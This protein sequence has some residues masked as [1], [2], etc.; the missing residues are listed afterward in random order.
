VNGKLTGDCIWFDSKTDKGMMEAHLIES[1]EVM[2]FAEQESQIRRL[3]FIEVGQINL[4][5]AIFAFSAMLMKYGPIKIYLGIHYVYCLGAYLSN[6][7][8]HKETNKMAFDTETKTKK[9]RKV[10][11]MVGRQKL[12]VPFVYDQSGT[13]GRSPAEI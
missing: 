7:T 3:T 1:L 6:W 9:S 4:T 11:Y 12:I 10:L 8:T 13:H 5:V 2:R